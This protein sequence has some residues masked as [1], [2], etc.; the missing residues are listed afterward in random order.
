[1]NISRFVHNWSIMWG[2]GRWEIRI[3]RPIWKLRIELIDWGP[4][5][6]RIR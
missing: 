1:M 6:K 3:W 4:R 2:L 5:W